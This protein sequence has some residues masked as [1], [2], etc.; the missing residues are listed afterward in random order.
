M[1]LQA[2]QRQGDLKAFLNNSVAAALLQP[3][4]AGGSTDS[5]A[6]I[7]SMLQQVLG[8]YQTQSNSS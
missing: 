1:Q 7:N 3:T 2:L 6:L 8:T 5:T 4:T